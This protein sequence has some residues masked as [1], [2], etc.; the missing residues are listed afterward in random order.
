MR[1]AYM[2]LSPAAGMVQ[3][4]A[5]L[6]NRRASA[7]DGVTVLACPSARLDRFASLIE[8]RRVSPIG[9]TGLQPA[10][11][12][13]DTLWR[14]FRMLTDLAPDVVHFTGPHP[15]SPVLLRLLRG[16]GVPAV[17]TI[18]DLDPHS[19]TGYGKLLYAWNALVFRYA[20]HVLVHGEVH[21]RRALANG[22]PADRVTA[23][24][25][26]HLFVSHSSE[27]QLALAAPDAELGNPPFALFFGR[28][29]AYKGVG[30]LLDALRHVESTAPSVHVVIAGKGDHIHRSHGSLPANV[31]V[32]NRLVGDD[33]AI[34][35][36][37]RCSVVVLPYV[38]A[39]QSALVGAAYFFGKP[40]IVTR[41]GALPEYVVES[42]T[43]WV[44]P[45]RDPRALAECLQAALG[46]PD[47]LARMGRAGRA[48]YDA[49]RVVEREALD[50]MYARVS[51]QYRMGGNKGP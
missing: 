17:H 9:G 48:W 22:I 27:Q 5:D 39:T 50:D 43:G 32:H 6:A 34:D 37:R 7:G 46:D 16:A 15:W 45:P 49:Q 20:G 36:F 35:L 24:P 38:D 31:E 2:V 44:I 19:G 10:N 1:L 25:L 12:R 14:T 8:V 47:R 28:L 33:E 41:V 29:E 26:L 30:V 18:H 40:V 11:L 21:R 4:A 42:E 13:F 3:Y 23:A 51:A